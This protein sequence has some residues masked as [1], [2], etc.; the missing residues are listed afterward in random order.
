MKFT[1]LI[2]AEDAN[3]ATGYRLI[4]DTMEIDRAAYSEYF[5]HDAPHEVERRIEDDVDSFFD[6][7]GFDRS[8]GDDGKMYGTRKPWW[9]DR[10]VIWCELK[11]V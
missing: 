7:F 1:K 2:D 4:F 9:S 3:V 11:E 10:P 8:L 5:R 6:T